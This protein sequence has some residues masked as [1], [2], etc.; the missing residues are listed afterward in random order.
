MMLR[1]ENL[2][3]KHFN[4]LVHNINNPVCK[5]R[6]LPLDSTGS[7]DCWNSQFFLFASLKIHREQHHH[8]EKLLIGLL[9]R[10]MYTLHYACIVKSFL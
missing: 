9:L 7:P 4:V 6:M 8:S 3:T 10:F 5:K 1:F 2:L